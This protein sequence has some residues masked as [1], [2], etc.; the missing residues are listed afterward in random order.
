MKC[1]N[2]NNEASW[3][4]NAEPYDGKMTYHIYL[5]SSS[6]SSISINNRFK[7]KLYCDA[8]IDAAIGKMLMLNKFESY[9][10]KECEERLVD[11]GYKHEVSKL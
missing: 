4:I 10:C 5:F 3:Q 11:K 6:S 7:T 8:C 2:C 1:F 9:Y